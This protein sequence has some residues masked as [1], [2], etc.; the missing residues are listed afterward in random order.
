MIFEI[1]LYLLIIVIVILLII[2]LTQID[3]DVGNILLVLLAIFGF[4]WLFG[5]IA[6]IDN[7][8]HN[9]YRADDAQQQCIQRGFDTYYSYSGIMRDKAYGVKCRY[10][11]YSRKQID[12]DN[13]DDSNDRI[14]VVS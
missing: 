4:V 12:I 5:G 2:L 14:V 13:K 3:D 8:M 9:P 6:I 7:F 10:E 11:D 1:S